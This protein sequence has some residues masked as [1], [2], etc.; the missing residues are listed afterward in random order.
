M[1][2]EGAFA[3]RSHEARRS[4]YQPGLG[5]RIAPPQRLITMLT[6]NTTAT[7]PAR[8]AR[9]SAGEANRSAQRYVAQANAAEQKIAA[10]NASSSALNERI[11]AVLARTTDQDL[12]SEPRAWWDWWRSHNEYEKPERRAVY[13]TV[14]DYN[15]YVSPPEPKECFVAGTP[16]WTKT[17]QRP[18]ETLVLGDLVLAQ[19]VDTGDLSYKPVIARTVR[20]PSEILK[21]SLGRDELR[22][23]KGHPIWIDG[24]GWRMAKE[25]NEGAQLHSVTDELR[26]E[27]VEADGMAE[28][29]N[30]VVADYGTYFV[31]RSGILVHDSTPRKPTRSIL[32]GIAA[33]PQPPRD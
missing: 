26:V 9:V 1:Y 30:L 17:G 3:D 8:P 12:G 10:V 22:T 33:P 7:P 2:Q 28:A 20:P 4:I 18:I 19:D 5:L 32:P 15:Q 31:G 16:V 21:F 27:K 13:A 14:D 24:A 6:G 29:Y 23:T 11:I 25:L